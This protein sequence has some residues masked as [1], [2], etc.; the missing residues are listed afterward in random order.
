MKKLLLIA[1]MVLFTSSIARADESLIPTD[2]VA[3][4]GVNYFVGTVIQ[5]GMKRQGYSRLSRILLSFT[6]DTSLSLLK[7]CTDPVF[8]WGD[9][10]A[11]G[12]GFGTAVVVTW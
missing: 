11:D 10:L 6:V 8:S 5:E 4:F 12:I 9:M 2:K 3:H 7:E 1:F